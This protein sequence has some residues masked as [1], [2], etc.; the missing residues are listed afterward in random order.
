MMI[1][2]LVLLRNY[3]HTFTCA[4]K[5]YFIYLQSCEKKTEKNKRERTKYYVLSDMWWLEPQSSL[6]ITKNYWINDFNFYLFEI[7]NQN[8]KWNICSFIFDTI[9]GILLYCVLVRR[10]VFSGFEFVDRRRT[11]EEIYFS[12]LPLFCSSSILTF[13]ILFRPLLLF[14]SFSFCLGFTLSFIVP[15]LYV[16]VLSVPY[17]LFL[18][19]KIVVGEQENGDTGGK[20]MRLRKHADNWTE[21]R[22]KT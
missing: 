8:A 12:L 10:P 21:R 16:L 19:L 18:M 1:H 14:C 6:T 20:C 2:T 17:I 4:A 9:I 7:T 11:S 5:D 13:Y 22:R 15:L 3:I